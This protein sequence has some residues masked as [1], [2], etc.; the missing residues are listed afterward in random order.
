VNE[1]AVNIKQNKS[2]HE[3]DSIVPIAPADNA[4][5]GAR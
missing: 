1:R 4:A 2:N 3:P 5:Y